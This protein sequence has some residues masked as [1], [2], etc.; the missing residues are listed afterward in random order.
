MSKYYG[1]V[2]FMLLCLMVI[3]FT[4]S[5]ALN[6]IL[7]GAF[8]LL[9]LVDYKNIPGYLRVYFRNSR[10]ILLLLIFCSLLLSVFYSHNQ[11][12]AWYAIIS[13]LPFFVLPL[14]LTRLKDL[15]PAQ[16]KVLKR[17][18]VASCVFASVICLI[19][20][21]I[22]SGLLD[23]SYKNMV[24][25]GWYMPHFVNHFTYHGLSSGLR[26]HAIYFSLFIALAVFF[27]IVALKNRPFKKRISLSVLLV[28]LL[29]FLILL[30]ATAIN[31]A[32]YSICL[33]YLYTVFSFK[34]WY[35]Y[36]LFFG[37]TIFATF[38]IFYLYTLKSIGLLEQGIYLFDSPTINANMFRLITSTLAFAVV[39][40]GIKLIFKKDNIRIAVA[41]G[42]I[43]VLAGG[44]MLVA[45]QAKKS[46]HR[47][48]SDNHVSNVDARLRTWTASRQL[49]KRHP[50]MGVGIGDER[51][52]LVHLYRLAGDKVSVENRFDT[53]SQYFQFWI[54][55]GI[56]SFLCFVILLI[57]EIYKSILY[58]N[59]ILLAFVY[60]FAILCLSESALNTQICRMFFLFF[61]CVLGSDS[62]RNP[63]GKRSVNQLW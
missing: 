30:K 3:S 39:A 2:F 27:T 33:L 16:L 60:T 13:Y 15:Q 35:H 52:S 25:P 57:S 10:N 18:H 36:F 40:I 45:M 26:L 50:L 7:I 23:G 42:G 49:I 12:K 59:I 5:R 11:Q 56:V 46:L 14:T 55:S 48:A 41:L 17:L 53:H 21:T 47:V 61:V 58:K 6:S 51:D 1:F 54:N 29:G 31:F 37:F 4:F 62:F 44:T 24:S 19:I 32:L 22:K 9:F 20:A 38:V 63:D 28:Y 8:S 43:V 34:K